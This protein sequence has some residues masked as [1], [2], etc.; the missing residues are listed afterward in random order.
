MRV[1]SFQTF[2]RENLTLIYRFVYSKL[3]NREDAEELTSQIFLKAV[4]GSDYQQSPQG[5]RKWLLQ[6]ARTTIADYWRIHYCT[7]M[8]IS[9][10]D[11]PLESGWEGPAEVEPSLAGGNPAARVERILQALPERDR[12]ALTCRFLLN[13]SVRETAL[14]MGLTERNVKKVQFRALKRAAQ[15][16][17]RA[18][19]NA[20]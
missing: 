13:L 12:E 4:R 7:G 11:G 2:Y 3:A 10:L 16:V 17:G 15:L 19:E 8:A 18:A 14:L 9:S 6:V 5:A 1:V 20:R